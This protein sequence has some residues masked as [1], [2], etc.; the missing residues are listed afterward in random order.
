MLSLV[1]ATPTTHPRWPL[2]FVCAVLMNWYCKQV[3]ATC[4]LWRRPPTRCMNALS[5]D[6]HELAFWVILQA[7]RFYVH[8][9]VCARCLR[10][11]CTFFVFIVRFLSND[12]PHY[13]LVAS[14]TQMLRQKVAR[15]LATFAWSHSEG[16]ACRANLPCFNKS[17]T[18]RSLSDVSLRACE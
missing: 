12:A 16:C 6:H 14:C 9:C 3:R 10:R 17:A 5:P 8:R 18:A 2:H 15:F 13:A 11:A 1:K 7:R 4:V